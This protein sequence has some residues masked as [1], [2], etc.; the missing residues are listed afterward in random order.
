MRRG[1]DGDGT[2]ECTRKHRRIAGRWA[3][4]C[5]TGLVSSCATESEKDVRCERRGDRNFRRCSSCRAS[6]IRAA[7]AWCRYSRYQC[8]ARPARPGA[9]SRAPR[10]PPFGRFG[11]PGRPRLAALGT[12]ASRGP[13]PGRT[14]SRTRSPNRHRPTPPADCDAGRMA[15]WTRP[16][17]CSGGPS[18]WKSSTSCDEDRSR[19]RYPEMSTSRRQ[20]A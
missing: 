15:R 16:T 11:T 14:R 19:V 10:R 9:A 4:S 17:R 6:E 2:T 7:H 20:R 5:Q 3:P 18:S 12:D 13:S 1:S 8:C